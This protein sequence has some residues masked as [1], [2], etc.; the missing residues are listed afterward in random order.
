MRCCGREPTKPKKDAEHQNFG[1]AGASTLRK[2][3]SVSAQIAPPSIHRQEAH[4]L[5]STGN[6]NTRAAR[7]V[8]G[9][10]EA[11]DAVRNA[12]GTE[13]PEARSRE[14]AHLTDAVERTDTGGGEQSAS[15]RVAEAAPS[16][17][18]G[19]ASVSGRF[20]GRPRS[21]VGRRAARDP[22]GGRSVQERQRQSWAWPRRSVSSERSRL[23]S[24]RSSKDSVLSSL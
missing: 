5:I 21:P 24:V 16:P 6:R 7:R 11:A 10:V 2:F 1:G 3:A 8:V 19:D 14:D 17:H 15:R 9:H 18:R 23:K 4:D 13:Q 20:A 22:A 12:R